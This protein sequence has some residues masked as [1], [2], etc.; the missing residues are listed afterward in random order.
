M[1]SVA[2]AAEAGSTRRGIGLPRR[3]F[4]AALAAAWAAAMLAIPGKATA[5]ESTAGEATARLVA[6]APP[7]AAG[8]PAPPTVLTAATPDTASPPTF[9]VRRFA[10]EGNTVLDPT[11]V[12]AALAAYLGEARSFADVQAAV[13]ALQAA[14]ARAGFGAVRV[15]LPE[16]TIASGTV[17][18]TVVEPQLRRVAIDGAD[19]FDADR[20]RRALPALSEGS[21]PNT[22]DLAAQIRLANDNPARRLSVELRS[23]ASGDIDAAVTV[24]EQK[25]WRIGVVVDNTGTPATGRVRSGM[26]FQH[27]N[28][29]ERD[30]VVTAQFVTAPEHTDRVAIGAFNSRVPLPGVGDAIDVFGVHADVD[31]GVVSEL[32]NVRGRGSVVGAR[33]QLNL[34]PTAAWRHRV[35]LG[36]ERR[37][38]DNHV[39]T[40]DGTD[41]VPDVTANPASIGYAASWSRERTLVELGAT[42]VRNLPGGAHGHAADFD[43]ARAGAPA[44]Y[45]LLRWSLAATQ[46]LPGDWQLR[47]S[48]EGQATRDALVSGEQFGIG[49][50]DSVRGFY[51]REIINDKG[52]RAGV[53]LRTPEAAAFGGSGTAQALAFYDVGRV[54]RNQPLPGE[55][56]Q[57][58]IASVG[59]GVRISIA[60]SATARLDVAH[61]LRGAGVRPRGDES[62]HFSIGLAY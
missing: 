59:V 49:G 47:L 11:R 38:F 60:P 55:V 8:E 17:R 7:E 56:A 30:H 16:Q 27:A 58:N 15:F 31:S 53:E 46:A 6:P 26:F 4:H 13:A 25:P 34:R 37:I 32:F 50:Q 20:I 21:T 54:T 18:I 52:V 19:A 43:A 14:Y 36:L 1:K 2:R 29:A 35:S 44:G 39:E 61:V 23:D 51:E 42:V 9:A 57:A 33:Y 48:A 24:R 41:L 3:A 40:F 45:G 22:D 12:D 62:V 28:V 5:N 10:V